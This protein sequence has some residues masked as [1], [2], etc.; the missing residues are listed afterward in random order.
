MAV[1]TVQPP[2]LSAL[3]DVLRPSLHNWKARYSPLH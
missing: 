1:D 3:L 2:N